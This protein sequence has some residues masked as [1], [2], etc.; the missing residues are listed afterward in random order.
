M[1]DLEAV[2]YYNQRVDACKNA[3]LKAILA[4]HRD[5]EKEQTVMLLEWIPRN[6]PMFDDGLK[7]IMFPD[8]TIAHA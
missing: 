4:Y 8:K 6:D 1:E 3:E 5:E 7:D 2:D